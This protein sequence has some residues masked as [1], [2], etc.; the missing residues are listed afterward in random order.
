LSSSLAGACT[1]AASQEEGPFYVALDR[2]RSDVRLGRAGVSLR[3]RV[4]VIHAST[5]RPLKGA[6]VDI[7]RA[8]GL[9]EYSDESSE[10]TLGQTWLRGVQLTD[11][12]GSRTRYSGG[13]LVHTG[14]LLF[15]EATST[16]VYRTSPYTR[17]ANT[18]TRNAADRVCI[19]QHG[20]SSI[21]RISGSPVTG[22]QGRITLAV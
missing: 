13:H 2:I 15:P 10:G 6:A 9:G 4:A 19:G 8:D 11:A 5:C 20:A 3:L 1:L 21:L 7:W 16:K 22:L 18:R 12:Q 17:D 14:Q